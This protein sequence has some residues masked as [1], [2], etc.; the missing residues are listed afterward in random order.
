MML[1]FW[2]RAMD[3]FLWLDWHRAWIWS[4]RRASD[5]T[6]WRPEDGPVGEEVDW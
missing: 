6:D 1:R 3:L 2:L 5:S 4:L